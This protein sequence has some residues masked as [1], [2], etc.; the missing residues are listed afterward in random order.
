MYSQRAICHIPCIFPK[1]KHTHECANQVEA[2][3]TGRLC[4]DGTAGLQ[5]AEGR[6]PRA[7]PTLMLTTLSSALET[8]AVT[9]L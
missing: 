1:T 3:D 5:P 7:R 2:G 8:A 4:P 9:E 6:N